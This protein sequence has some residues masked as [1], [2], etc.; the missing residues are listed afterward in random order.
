M[1]IGT[2]NFD[3]RSFAHNEE[4]NVCVFDRELASSFSDLS[5][6]LGGCERVTLERVGAAGVWAR[7]QE[8]V[9]CVPPGAGMTR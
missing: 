6:D 7:M 5:R 8:F 9:A 1:T 3:N 4:S 2:A